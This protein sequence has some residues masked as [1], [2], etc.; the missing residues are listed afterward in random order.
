[1]EKTFIYI[2]IAVVWIVVSIVRASNKANKKKAAPASAAPPKQGNQDFNKVLEELLGIKKPEPAPAAPAIPVQDKPSKPKFASATLT[3]ESVEAGASMEYLNNYSF[4]DNL[5]GNIS[6]RSGEKRS[7]EKV[8]RPRLEFDL[9]QAVIYSAILN[10][11][12]S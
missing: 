7:E 6:G 4:S 2:L 1:M 3:K 11:P 12:Y 8:S 10:R 5:A 9:K